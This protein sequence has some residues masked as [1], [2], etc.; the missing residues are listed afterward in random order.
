MLDRE[1]VYDINSKE[2]FDFFVDSIC[3]IIK[4][5]NDSGAS[6]QAISSLSQSTIEIII[7][8]I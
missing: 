7:H 6:E 8:I 5:S 4:L 1:K 3:S 2:I